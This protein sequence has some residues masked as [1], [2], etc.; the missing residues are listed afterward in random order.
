[1]TVLVEDMI[2]KDSYSPIKLTQLHHDIEN[3]SGQVRRL[4]RTRDMNLLGTGP[5]S[6]ERG[7]EVWILA[8]GEVPYILRRT[9]PSSKTTNG[10]SRHRLVGETY[11][12][13]IMHGDPYRFGCKFASTVL[14]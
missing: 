6:V 2:A 4:F 9:D 12:H 5:R 13:G 10:E 3:G 11:V 7:D 1:M 8:G 14:E